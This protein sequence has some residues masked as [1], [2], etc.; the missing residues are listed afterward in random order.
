MGHF[1]KARRIGAE[2]VLAF[3][4]AGGAKGGDGG[5]V[6][7]AVA[8]QDLDFFFLAA[9]VGALAD[10][11]VGLFVGLG[12]A[13]GNV[14]ARQA[15]HVFQKLFGKFNGGQV[16]GRGGVVG[17]FFHLV[18]NGVGDPV[19]AVAHVHAPDAAG[20][21]VQVFLAVNVLYAQSLAF[22]HDHGGFALVFE[23]VVP[24]GFG[25]RIDKVRRALGHGALPL[26]CSADAAAGCGRF[27]INDGFPLRRF[28][29]RG[30]FQLH[31]GRFPCFRNSG[32]PENLMF[33]AG[34]GW[35]YLCYAES[36]PLRRVNRNTRKW[37]RRSHGKQK[38][39]AKKT[40]CLAAPCR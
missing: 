10:H 34:Y 35:Q 5:A 32:A 14:H 18:A 7:V 3:G 26:C 37:R 4:L 21:G 36:V 33:P 31:P 28:Q 25:V 13:V 6:V 24:Y 17:H 12:A 27:F 2:Q 19:A 9:V 38:A 29:P 22:H 15:G 11:L 1:H 39:N 16:A 40:C 23:Q 8:V 30:D 20:G